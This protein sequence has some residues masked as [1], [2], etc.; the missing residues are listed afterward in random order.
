MASLATDCSS[1]WVTT[2]QFKSRLCAVSSEHVHFQNKMHD[3]R[4]VLYCSQK[5]V[6]IR[7]RSQ[8]H[9]SFWYILCCPCSFW[10]RLLNMDALHVC[11][12][13]SVCVCVCDGCRR[14]R[15]EVGGRSSLVL[16]WHWIQTSSLSSVP[17]IWVVA[18]AAVAPPP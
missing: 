13:V 5:Y 9:N 7:L 18:M 10:H 15:V 4:M 11:Q 14:I 3:P 12:C 17:T 6:V 2:V 8:D 1:G 16:V